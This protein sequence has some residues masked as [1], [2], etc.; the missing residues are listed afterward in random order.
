MPIYAFRCRKCSHEYEELVQRVGQSAPC[1]KCGHKRVE[2]LVSA[3]AAGRSSKSSGGA[4]CSIS[5]G[6]GIS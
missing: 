6:P 3:P 4:A 2:R 1:P 5:S